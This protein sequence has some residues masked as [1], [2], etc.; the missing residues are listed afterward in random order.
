MTRA[1]FLSSILFGLALCGWV[2]D[3]NLSVLGLVF[4]VL[5]LGGA[6]LNERSW[7]RALV[8]DRTE[9][10]PVAGLSRR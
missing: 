10:E 7:R 8:R 2:G 9:D 6:V 1:L 5:F 4:S 3:Q